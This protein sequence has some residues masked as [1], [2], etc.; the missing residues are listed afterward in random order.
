MLKLLSQFKMKRY[1]VTRWHQ[2]KKIIRLWRSFS[3]PMGRQLSAA[4]AVFSDIFFLLWLLFSSKNCDFDEYFRF[5][6]LYHSSFDYFYDLDFFFF[7]LCSRIHFLVQKC[8]QICFSINSN[9]TNNNAHIE[10]STYDF[11]LFF[12]ILLLLFFL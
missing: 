6:A 1:Y 9:K 3:L 5:T 2:N 7:Y 4:A 11:S 12:P 10:V 8:I